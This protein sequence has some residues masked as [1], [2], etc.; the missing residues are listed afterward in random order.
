M[1]LYVSKEQPQFGDSHHFAPRG[2]DSTDTASV[3][4]HRRTYSHSL[5]RFPFMH[6]LCSPK[7]QTSY[8]GG[9]SEIHIP[10]D[11]L[12]STL[13]SLTFYSTLS[14]S[15]S[16]DTRIIRTLILN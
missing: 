6:F 7:T 1:T 4:V 2:G 15:T 3:R 13:S 5:S 14:S 11:S 12:P 16:F 9:H 8:L 10:S